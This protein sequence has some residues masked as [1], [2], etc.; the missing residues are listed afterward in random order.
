MSTSQNMQISEMLINRNKSSSLG[1]GY[2]EVQLAKELP[3]LGLF[4]KQENSHDS[5][6]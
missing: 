1:R 3:W 6:D 2:R 4:S 5:E